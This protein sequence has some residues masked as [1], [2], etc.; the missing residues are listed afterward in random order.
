MHVGLI[1]NVDIDYGLDVANALDEAGVSVT[2]YLSRSH[3]VRSV[4]CADRPVERFYE[5]GLLR[6]T[7]QLRLF[8]LPRMRDPRSL[9]AMRDLC[10]NLYADGI[11][12][13]HILVG[14]GEFWLGALACLLRNIPVVSTMITPVPHQGDKPPAIVVRAGYRLLAV[15]SDQVIVNGTSQVKLV[16]KVYGLAP[17]RVNYVPLGGRTT[18]LRWSKEKIC[19]EPGTILFFGAARPHKG[20]EYLVR[21]QPS[22]TR[23]CPDARVIIASSGKDLERCRTLIE[24]DSKFEIHSGFVPGNTMAALFQKSS[25]VVLPYLSAASSGVLMTALVFGKPVVATQIDGLTEYVNDGVTGILVPPANVTEL[26]NALIQLL[27][28]HPLRQRMGE[29]ARCWVNQLQTRVIDGTLLAYEQ[30][31]LS[32]QAVITSSFNQR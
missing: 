8:Q 12:I 10:Q 19:E 5:L 7:C 26:A 31:K 18:A 30:A 13:A 4:E 16:Q 1:C 17:Q 25:L 20:L 14:P 9:N 3:A 29:N 24:D 32:H 21:A 15:G 23:R 28:D 11:N 22:V 27:S 2:L 6:S